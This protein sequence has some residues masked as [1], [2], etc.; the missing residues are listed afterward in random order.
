[1][2][3]RQHIYYFDY[4]RIIACVSVIFMHTA[5]GFLRG[6]LCG[7]WHVT[8]IITNFAFTAVPLFFMMSGYL[9]ISSEKTLDVTV[10]FKKRLPRLVV[11]L[12]FW[13]VVAVLWNMFMARSFTVSGFVDRIVSS[14]ANPAA[15]HFWYMYTLIAVYLISPVVA[16][17]IRA[18]DKKGRILVFALCAAVSVKYMI[19]CILPTPLDKYVEF[20]VVN[21]M[22]FFSGYFCLFVM[23]YF[24][25]DLKKKIPAYI[26]VPVALVTWGGVNYATYHYTVK[27]GE[28][29]QLFNAQSMGYEV[30]LAACLF[31]IFKQF[32]NRE[33]IVTKRIPIVPL[34]L[35]IY[36][37]HNILL[38]M[39]YSV[40]ISTNSLMKVIG[41]T[42]LNLVIS[43]LAMKTA[44]TIKPLCFIVTGIPFK[45]A[46]STCNWIFT[47]RWIKE[48]AL[49]RKAARS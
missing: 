8:N 20:D 40:G 5:A 29:S 37:M 36:L 30:V 47:Y 11:P 24:L 39:M 16:G 48:A 25:G 12:A 9:L 22:S 15:V 23:G 6:T 46:C 32:F 7:Q 1:M 34:S 10:L 19:Q 45:E 28:Y 42:L 35:P 3:E 14:F 49:K 21:K 44:A 33:W 4:L 38:S 31:L 13:T 17:G 2:K 43:F 27:A 26:L 18:L 41:V